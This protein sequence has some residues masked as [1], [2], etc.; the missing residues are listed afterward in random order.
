MRFFLVTVLLQEYN[1]CMKH[2]LTIYHGSEH[3]VR[4][5]LYGYGRKNNDYGSGFYCTMDLE[6]AKEW[7]AR[8]PV[9]D[10]FVN[11]YSFDATG[12]DVL[13]LSREPALVWLTVLLENR[14]FSV[15]G[16]LAAS[17]SAY[18]RDNFMPDYETADVIYGWRADDSYFAYANDFI[19]GALSLQSLKKAMTFGNLGMQYVLKSKK[20]FSRIIFEDAI[21][22]SAKEYYKKRMKRDQEA[23]ESYLYDERFVF[24]KDD[25][26]VTDIIR[27]EIKKDDPRIQ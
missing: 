27:Q 20:A 15:K 5:P 25:L 13:D 18:L 4:E 12:L 2:L 21:R 1:A 17:A 3:T 8:N 16:S 9:K 11:I 7:S 10:G 23:R 26:Y 24:E 19:N 6:L 14:T 22:T